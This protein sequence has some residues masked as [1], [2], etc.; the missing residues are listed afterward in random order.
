MTTRQ[1]PDGRVELRLSGAGGQGLI[2]AGVILSEAAVRDGL[3][4]VQTQSYGPEARL[5]AS[6]AEVI[7][8]R[9]TIAYPQVVKPDVI[10]CLSQDSFDKYIGDA[11]EATLVIVDAT[12]VELDG[13][14]SEA[15]IHAFPITE[16][17]I[18]VGHKVVANV[19][20]LGALNALAAVVSAESL[21]AAVLRRV[22][23]K[24]RDLNAQALDAGQA[25]VMES[26]P[27][28]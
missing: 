13:S 19:V 1:A 7:V 24:H 10:L 18:E 5:G 6:R 14:S 12:F 17:A 11:D 15:Q 2:T 16:T 23:D 22:P 8:A 4:V 28:S 9:E 20:A 25:L 27:A 3:E 21:K 26:A